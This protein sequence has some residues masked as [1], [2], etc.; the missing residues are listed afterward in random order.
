MLVPLAEVLALPSFRAA[1]VD[2]VAG[3]PE[4]VLVRWVHSSE[5]YEMGTLLAGGEVLLSTGLGLHGR[6]AEQ[7][8]AY[9]EQLADAG[10]AALGLELGRSL[11]VVPEAMLAAARRRGLVVLAL[12]SVVPF[13]RMVEDF[14]SLLVQRKL[15]AAG[16][17]EAL[18]RDL[19]ATVVAGQ[20]MRALLDAAARAAGCRVELVDLEG[21]V[22]ER[23]SISAPA[24][25]GTTAVEVRTASG[26]AGTLV[27]ASDDPAVAAVAER[28]AV[29]VAL[30]L[31]R[32]P[33]L[34]QRPSLAQAVVTDL[35]A[36][37]LVGATEVARRLQD[38]GWRLPEGQQ[39]AVVAVAG[40]PRTPAVEVL[41]EVE[42][43]FAAVAGPVLA[44]AVGADLVVLLRAPSSAQRLRAVV[45][46]V[47]AT[48]PSASGLGSALVGVSAGT[49]DPAVVPAAVV[50]AR[51]VLR[52]ARRS[53][54][55]AG[56]LLARDTGLAR[57]LVRAEPQALGDLVV[58]QLGPLID[59]DRAH[60]ADLVRT[61]DAYL[62][63]GSS[64]AE[65]ARRLGIR[66][67]SLYA[68]LDRIERLLGVD[69]ASSQHLAGLTV[70]LT[71]WRL[72]TGLDPQVAFARSSR[73]R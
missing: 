35:A 64:K 20:G 71:A 9:V 21:Q 73:A 48:A 51:E 36:G 8:A 34:G 11:F 24:C 69:L 5:V 29:A 4:A 33:S 30:E 52:H 59:H 44:G 66:R 39:V 14:H 68:R 70:A 26:P 61:L 19:L 72:R 6:S 1:A 42:R 2:V 58:E 32:H 40:D 13:E 63:A 16:S 10:C 28:A 17:D 67:Q 57:L 54:V 62:A 22:V 38:A 46:E 47:V 12:T 25:E 56:V 45:E 7:L 15:G 65:T 27:L 31:G 18:W 53:G 37:T 50:R 43:A 55:T 41:P 3:D 23:S 60:A 49:T